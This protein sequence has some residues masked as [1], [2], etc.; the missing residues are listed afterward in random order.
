MGAQAATFIL[1]ASGMPFFLTESALEKPRF[2]EYFRLRFGFD[3]LK[4]LVLIM[5][6][7]F[8]AVGIGLVLY[9]MYY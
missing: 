1:L 8:F 2:G 7:L 5:L 3:I 4:W 9:E 6:P